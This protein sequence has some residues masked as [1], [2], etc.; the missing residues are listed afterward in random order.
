MIRYSNGSYHHILNLFKREGS[1]FP[2]ALKVALPCSALSAGLKL[3]VG[4]GK[5]RSFGWHEDHKILENAPWNS[6]SFLVGF[7]IVFRTSQSYSRFWDA[8]GCTAAMRSHW[9]DA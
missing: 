5:L 9:F 8:C 4:M 3:L 2:F 6:F 1:T 7:L